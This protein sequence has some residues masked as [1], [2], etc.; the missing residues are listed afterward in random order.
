MGQEQAPRPVH[1]ASQLSII[2]AMPACVLPPGRAVNGSNSYMRAA[3]ASEALSQPARLLRRGA[4]N[5]TAVC[6]TSA[7]G[8]DLLVR[9]SLLGGDCSRPS[10]VHVEQ[11]R[12]KKSNILEEHDHLV[13]LLLLLQRWVPEAVHHWCHARQEAQLQ[14][15]ASQLSGW[16]VLSS[17]ASQESGQLL[18]RAHQEEGTHARAKYKQDPM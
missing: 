9:L 18:Q 8:D 11:E 13:H 4:Q 17:G 5:T 3:R 2:A 1:P 14:T 16:A 6:S 12:T 7:A 15:H 10:H